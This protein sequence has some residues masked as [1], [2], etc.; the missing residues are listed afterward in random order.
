MED[1]FVLFPVSGQ[2]EEKI[3]GGYR[4]GPGNEDCNPG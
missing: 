1:F 3:F 2:V 4:L